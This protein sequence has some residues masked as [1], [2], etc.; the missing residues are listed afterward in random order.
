MET[1]LKTTME[2][3]HHILNVIGTRLQDTPGA[4]ITLVGCNSGVGNENIA[5]SQR[6]AA[7]VK[8]YFTTLWGINPARITTKSRGLPEVA[9]TSTDPSGQVE[10]QRVEIV[11]DDP[12]IL[13]TIKSTYF[14]AA[15]DSDE[16]FI[17]PSIQSEAG[18][19]RWRISLL[20]DNRVLKKVEG[21][22]AIP[23]KLAFDI[24]SFGLATMVQFKSLRAVMEVEDREQ[25]IRKL[26]SATPVTVVFQ[27][28]QERL[29]RKLGYRVI[30]RYALILFAFDKAEIT[31]RNQ[32]IVDHIV[33]RIQALPD[34]LVN[35]IGHTD[36]IGKEDYNMALSI[37]RANAV[38]KKMAAVGPS[39][40]KRT[41]M[42]GD[43]AHNP[44]YD[45]NLP[46]GRAFNRTVTVTIKYEKPN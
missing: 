41:T 16:I 4:V 22:G 23:S 10:N 25:N 43:G 21:Q 40:L 33:K 34:A 12:A 37:R 46:E 18:I 29:A 42:F 19:E 2:K 13:D 20:G 1:D 24:Y 30:E 26:E 6:R 8:R 5:L 17:M 14:S 32:M 31:G 44:P 36:I 11:S 7:S 9:S 15:S 28:H 3:Y 38:F 27:K 35:V 45:N 39:A